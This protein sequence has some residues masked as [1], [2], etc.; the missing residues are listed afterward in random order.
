MEEAQQERLEDAGTKTFTREEAEWVVKEYHQTLCI[1]FTNDDHTI[2]ETLTMNI[3]KTRVY[4]E[5]PST[6]YTYVKLRN[7]GLFDNYQHADAPFN[8]NIVESL[9]N[10]LVQTLED[11]QEYKYECRRR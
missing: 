4:K 8:L 5:Y 3:G 11:N 2:A 1:F 10:R 6:V 9:T 7:K